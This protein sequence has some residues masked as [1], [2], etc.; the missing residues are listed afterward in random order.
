M[1][2]SLILRFFLLIRNNDSNN[3]KTSP[4]SFSGIHNSGFGDASAENGFITSAPAALA[5]NA[6][7][8][9]HHTYHGHT[10][11]YR[12][13]LNSNPAMLEQT[14]NLPP[15][16]QSLLDQSFELPNY[17]TSSGQQPI[18]QIILT[19]SNTPNMSNRATSKQQQHDYNSHDSEVSH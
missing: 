15:V 14:N 13:P 10:V 6:P 7:R 17:P 5:S 18:N 8:Y 11:H 2:H 3:S 9:P 16:D 1:K 12:T 19:A 4:V